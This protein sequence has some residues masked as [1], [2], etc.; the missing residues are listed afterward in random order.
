MIRFEATPITLDAAA[1]GSTEPRRTITGL[2]IPWNVEA[3]VSTG[4]RVK[5]LE[6]SL[7]VDGP[8][9]VLLEFHDSSRPVGIVTQRVS[10]STG[11]MFEAKLSDTN[12]GRDSM[13]LM[14]DNVIT[15]VS[16]G[17]EPIDYTIDKK[18][19]TMTVT[20]ATWSELSLVTAG[21]FSDAKILQVAASTPEDDEPQPEEKEEE[22]SEPIETAVVEAATKPTEL[23]FAAPKKE[24]KWPTPVEYIQASLA[25]GSVFAEM[26]AKIRAAAPDIITSDVP[27]IIPEP[28][29]API[30][31]NFRGMRPVVDSFGVRSMP[32]AGGTFIRPSVTTHVSQGV[33]STQN[34]ALTQGT[35]VVTANTVTKYTFGGYVD[36]SEQTLD[37][38]QPEVLGALLD[39]MARIYANGTDNKTADDF[40]AAVTNDNAFAD[41]TVPADWAAWIA[42]AASD[43]LTDS[44][45]NL[46]NTLWC[47]ADVWGDLLRLTDDAGRPLFP[48][49]GPYNA[50]GELS[51]DRD[52][53]TAFGMRVVVDRNFAADTL[54]LGDPSGFECFEQQK[55]ALSVNNASTLSTTIAFRGY[56]ATLM[57]DATK[58]IKASSY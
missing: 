43:I 24:F 7:P 27:G 29:L 39:D 54:I 46:P 12:N 45:G 52:F 14:L 23:L 4:Q 47:S 41:P 58:F 53:G 22:M 28:I 30:Y 25:G 31:N 2:A 51:A 49:V 44:N 50:Y 33:Q 57:I 48:N 32:A 26:N 21:A 8:A 17:A 37:F 56:F 38:S 34:T 15:A 40:K 16:V 35:M 10:D 36:V 42:Q 18:T 3:T 6:G 20:K 55:G 13:T 5:F 11:M 19:G 1:P 9:P